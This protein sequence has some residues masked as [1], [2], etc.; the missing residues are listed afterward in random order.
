[1]TRRRFF[2]VAL[3]EPDLLDAE[4][5]G[6][7]LRRQSKTKGGDPLIDP[8]IAARRAIVVAEEAAVGN[9]RR[10]RQAAAGITVVIVVSGVILGMLSPLASVHKIEVVGVDHTDAGEVRLASGLAG[11]PPLVR[12]D[13]AEVRAR[14]A[15]LPWV[16]QVRVERRWPQ[17][18]VLSI[19]ERK[20]AAV[21][22]CQVAA[23][24]TSCLVDASGRVLAP[25]AEDPKAAFGL[26]RLDGVPLSGEVG[27][28]LP[29]LSRGPLAVAVALPDALRPLVLGIRG[30]G[31]EVALDLLVPGRA[32]SPPVVRMGAPVRIF[33]KL[34]AVVTVLARTSVNG[35]AVLDVRVPE[36]P[37]LSRIPR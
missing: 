8:R 19:D 30:E 9:R 22:S 7:R 20:P 11:G 2:D 28:T 21:I 17:T 6:R 23:A 32:A 1:M 18:V 16:R 10:R 5:R 27:T 14:V 25:I 13:A 35:V 29:E 15:V 24:T 31:A 34:T 26:P 3:E 4:R 37:A 12:L 33:D 36:A